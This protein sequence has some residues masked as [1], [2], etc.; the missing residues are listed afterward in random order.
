LILPGA[1]GAVLWLFGSALQG[2]FG[3]MKLLTV[4]FLAC[5]LVL[6]VATPVLAQES[7]G[8]HT[9]ALSG[10]AV[11]AG[12]GAGITLIG[13]GVGFG[14]IGASALE[15]MA[16][17]PEIAGQ[18]QTAMIVIAALLE[19]ATFFALVVC[20]LMTNSVKF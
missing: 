9:Y 2:V 13:A 1:A 18:I 8:S 11:G 20:I 14:R 10:A 3:M 15:S 6:L 16:R 19:G 17:Q 7:A 12:I 5:V 4:V